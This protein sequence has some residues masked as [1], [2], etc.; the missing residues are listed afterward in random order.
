M[1]VTDPLA[2]QV[3]VVNF[4]TMS[5]TRMPGGTPSSLVA[6]PPPLEGQKVAAQDAIVHTANHTMLCCQCLF[7]AG[8]APL[9]SKP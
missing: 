1:T 9:K 3:I 4:E 6:L 8:P 5:S 2:P 7:L